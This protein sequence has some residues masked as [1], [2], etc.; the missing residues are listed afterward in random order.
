MADLPTG[1]V[2]FLLTD[3]E[4]STALWEEAP[5]TMRAA[6]VRHD[7]LF[8]DAIHE[9]GGL[10]IRPRGEGDSRFAVFSS[11]PTAIS[12]VLAIQR[13]LAAETWPTPRPIEVRVGIHTGEAGLREATGSPVSLNERPLSERVATMIRTNLCD[14][15]YDVAFAEGRAMPMEQA[16]ELALELAAEIQA[17]VPTSRPGRSER[18]GEP[19]PGTR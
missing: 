9:H 10:H 3:V 1:T 6:L 13:A 11:A 7:V 5:E 8:E 16:V 17:A 12:A 4:G 2:T 14:H 19:D 18:A 15:A